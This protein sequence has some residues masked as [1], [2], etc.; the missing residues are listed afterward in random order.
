MRTHQSQLLANRASSMRAAPTATEALLWEALKGSRLAGVAFRRQ[1]VLG[2]YIA[3]FAAMR[4]KLVIEVDGGYHAER[5]RADARRDRELGRMGYRVVHVPA[6][7]VTRDIER[8]KALVLEAL[9]G[10]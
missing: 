1:V 10:A 2:R 8:A 3:D 7:L 9:S 6:E 5:V 4:E